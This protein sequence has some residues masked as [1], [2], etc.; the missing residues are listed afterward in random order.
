LCLRNLM[1]DAGSTDPALR[2]L[3]QFRQSLQKVA[4]RSSS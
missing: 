2:Q 1:M 4:E 3:Q